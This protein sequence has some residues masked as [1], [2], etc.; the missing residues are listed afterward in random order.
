M[1]SNPYIQQARQRDPRYA[2]AQQLMQQGSS[3]APVQSIGEAFA[4]AL[5]APLGGY[6]QSQANKDYD[7]K[8]EGYR[9]ALAAALQGDNPIDALAASTDPYLQNMGLEAKLQKS[10]Q[11]PG[12]SWSTLTDDQEKGLGLDTGG[13]YQQSNSGG[14]KVVQEPAK[15]RQIGETRDFL[16]GSQKVTQEWDG[17]KWSDIG[18]GPAYAPPAP[19]TTW[20]TV[21]DES[22]KPLY[23]ESDRGERKALPG[24][25]MGGTFKDANTLR[26]EYN[27]LTKDF[28]TVQDAYNK[29]KSTSDTGA[30]DMSL[31]YSYV[32]LLDPGSVVRE[33]EFAT[34]AASGSFG[35]Q[36]QGAVQRL[37]TGER[38]PDTLRTAFKSEA[39]SI[40]NAQKMGYDQTR[41][42]YKEIAGRYNVNPAD[43]LVDYATPAAP[44]LG[45]GKISPDR[46]NELNQILGMP[47]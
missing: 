10:M 33:S 23:Q 14:L 12:E 42:A 45:N 15:G 18:A 29:I 35:E 13:I 46:L 1:Y 40:Y 37:M 43:V 4:R 6:F 19:V 20:R 17:A 26:D 22:G 9:K 38:L 11:A 34:A 32:K 21:T 27:T 8:D 3:T 2:Y 31:L 41:N 25:E 44:I 7:A 24:Q 36:V 30:G 28:R 47:E 39:D 16:R 5:Q